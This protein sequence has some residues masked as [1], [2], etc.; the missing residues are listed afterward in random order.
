MIERENLPYRKGVG[1][2]ILNYNLEVFVGMRID[3]KQEAWQM[4]QGGIDD[5]EDRFDAALREMEE[6]TGSKNAKIIAETQ[7]WYSYDLPDY[8]I[9]KLWDGKYRGQKQK[10]FLIQFLGTDDEFNISASKNAE[11][12][13]WKWSKIEE[14]PNIIIN[15]KRDLYIS[16]IEE[17]RDYI[18]QLKIDAKKQ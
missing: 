12:M 3:S 14:L 7:N 11:F 4:P 18:I 2:M 1:L 9:P 5:G 15:F 10:W 17:F 6:E 13:Q 8:L 16:V